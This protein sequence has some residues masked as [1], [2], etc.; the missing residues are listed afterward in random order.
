MVVSRE[1]VV[2]YC[3]RRKLNKSHECQIETAHGHQ[4]PEVVEE[5]LNIALLEKN[6][7]QCHNIASR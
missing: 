6:N 1:E 3:L 7:E 5:R 4:P 2:Y